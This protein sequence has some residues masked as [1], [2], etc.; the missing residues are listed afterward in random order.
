MRYSHIDELNMDEM[1][2]LLPSVVSIRHEVKSGG[3]TRREWLGDDY[4]F[5][6]IRGSVRFDIKSS[7]CRRTTWCSSRP[8]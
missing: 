6:L 2:Y 7:C 1:L 4:L 3:E 8:A 5:F